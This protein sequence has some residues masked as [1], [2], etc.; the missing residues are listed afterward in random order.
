MG[1]CARVRVVDVI[2][3]GGRMVDVAAHGF[4][5]RFHSNCGDT[6]HDFAGDDVDS[7]GV[8][9]LGFIWPWRH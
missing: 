4:T 7:H 9:G 8:A 2:G 3:G 1:V 5:Q 6:C